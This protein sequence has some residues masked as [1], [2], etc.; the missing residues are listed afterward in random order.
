[1]ELLRYPADDFV[2]AFVGKERRLAA[3]AD[4]TVADVMVRRPVSVVAGMGLQ[5]A[6]ALM[7]KRRV[8]SLLVVDGDGRF[9][10]VVYPEDIRDKHL[11]AATVGDLARRD[12][13]VIEPGASLHEGF[14]LMVESGTRH[15]P[16][17]EAGGRLVGLLTHTNLVDYLA[18]VL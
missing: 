15:L 12:H 6:L 3:G 5:Q 16:V 2:A 4:V 17:V 7:R 1:E 8:D 14:R 10:G 18:Q 11:E 13:P 9:L